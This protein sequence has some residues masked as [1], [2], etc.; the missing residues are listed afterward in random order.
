M[1]PTSTAMLSQNTTLSIL[2]IINKF[3]V[4]RTACAP[5]GLVKSTVSTENLVHSAS[6]QIWNKHKNLHNPTML[7]VCNIKTKKIPHM[8]DTNSLDRCG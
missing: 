4:H 3:T 6:A 1:K 7:C 8:G 2:K 5:L